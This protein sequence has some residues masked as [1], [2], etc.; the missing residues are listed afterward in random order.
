MN[1]SLLFPSG[2]TCLFVGAK[3]EEIYPPKL[4]E[5]AYVTDGACGE[6]E[7]LQ[8]ELVVLKK[9]NW[10]LSPMTP[11]AWMK[12]YMQSS[13]ATEDEDA[14][15]GSSFV[16]AK[17][18]GVPFARAMR[19]LDL[20]VLDLGSLAFNYSTLAAA[21]LALTDGRAVALAASCLRWEEDGLA[22]CV[23][24]LF[25]YKS[26]LDEDEAAKAV[27]GEVSSAPAAKALSTIAPEDLH[28]IQ[29]HATELAV[30]DRAQEIQA[31]RSRA[32]PDLSKNPSL[33][34]VDMT[35]PE[36][37]GDKRLSGSS[38]LQP[39][40]TTPAGITSSSDQQSSVFFSP[41][42]PNSGANQHQTRQTLKPTSSVLLR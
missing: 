19:L 29:T 35:P 39:L 3:I 11:N 16:T 23:N 25:A 6:E 2:V 24:W 21:A 26:A 1:T 14:T 40:P 17:F 5:F 12:L 9:L 22:R 37:D 27:S 42:T 4:S 31:A 28:N 34:Q 10:G 7:I 30:L 8:M 13:C 33:L 20:A 18:S 38:Y 36:L 41:N 32:S 15:S